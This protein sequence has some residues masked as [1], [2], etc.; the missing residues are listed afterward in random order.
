MF[1][2]EI[3]DGVVILGLAIFGV[4]WMCGWVLMRS[5]QPLVVQSQDSQPPAISVIIPARNEAHNIVLLIEG[6]RQQIR[7]IDEIV[8]G[9]MTTKEKLEDKPDKEN[10]S[11]NI[12]RR[13][14]KTK[15]DTVKS[16]SLT[17]TQS[18]IAE[19]EESRN[20]ETSKKKSDKNKKSD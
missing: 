12:K 16:T 20:E 8:R 7:T 13:N 5:V 10:E 15:D 1:V 9:T 11:K 19:M 2:H 6:L 3:Y 17:R 4:C 14:N 18:K